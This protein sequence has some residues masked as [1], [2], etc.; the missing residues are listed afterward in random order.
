MKNSPLFIC[1]YGKKYLSLSKKLKDMKKNLFLFLLL[2]LT[3]NVN[4]KE[5]KVER[6]GETL[7][8][9]LLTIDNNIYIDIKSDNLT[10]HSII[11]FWLDEYIGLKQKYISC[12]C[13][14]NCIVKYDDNIPIYRF[15]INKVYFKD[16]LYKCISV[17]IGNKW[18]II[19]RRNIGYFKNFLFNYIITSYDTQLR[20]L[21]MERDSLIIVNSNIS[22]EDI[23]PYNEI[24]TLNNK[25]H[26]LNE[27]ENVN[28]PTKTTTK[29]K[30]EKVTE[31]EKVYPTY[32]KGK[33]LYKYKYKYWRNGRWNYRY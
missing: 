12:N 31:G 6:C 33:P 10:N 15:F 4:A 25:I 18:K 9:E 28:I 30:Y 22:N 16:I 26:K 13:S 29:R 5:F 32:I 27:K 23:K 11:Y 24:P 8:F 1:I 19:P 14:E 20:E 17:S 3:L 7:Y 2:F 21:T